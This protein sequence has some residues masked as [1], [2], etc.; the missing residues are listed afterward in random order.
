MV[1][2]SSKKI[3]SK[4]LAVQILIEEREKRSLSIV[5]ASKQLSICPSF[6]ANL[7][8][9]LYNKL[10]GEIYIKNFIKRYAELLG[11]NPQKILNDY[12]E[13]RKDCQKKENNF[14]PVCRLKSWPLLWRKL[15][16]LSAVMI[17]VIYLGIEING[18]FIA[19]ALDLETPTEGEV[20]LQ[21][22][23]SVK[24]KT[25]P[26]LT[27]QINGVETVSDSLGNFSEDIILNPGS[28][29]IIITA[30]KKHS[31]SQTVIRNV[32]YREKKEDVSLKK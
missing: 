18:I 6:V 31:R 29:Q 32:I 4:P 3:A 11:L 24:G 5:S 21:E 17:L 16:A 14:I 13:E 26:E 28:N 22:A 9:G 20:S 10:P 27:V 15:L 25:L 12:Q 23:L 7:E 8:K 19:P 1:T 30:A 2:F